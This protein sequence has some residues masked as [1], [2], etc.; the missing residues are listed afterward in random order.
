MPATSDPAWPRAALLRCRVLAL[1]LSLVLAVGPTGRPGVDGC[2][3]ASSMHP[4]QAF[5]SA[6]VVLR[7]RIVGRKIV[8]GHF[9]LTS[10]GHPFQMVLHRVKQIKIYKGMELLGEVTQ[11]YTPTMD[12]LCAPSLDLSKT[13]Y[14]ITG[15]IRDGRVSVSGCD[16]VQPWEGLT[17]SQKKSLSYRYRMGCDCKI[18]ECRSLPCGEGSAD[19]CVWTDRVAR[20]THAGHQ[21][22]HYA[23]VRRGDGPCGWYKGGLAPPN[24][25]LCEGAS[26]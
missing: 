3:C 26:P 21:A 25:E 1:A 23:C 13:Q 8:V 17:L 11:L 14:V 24:T 19:E 10:H 12:G 22:K 9:N 18:R 4:Q 20:G 7:A 6:D 2:S 15:K 5:C 16:Y